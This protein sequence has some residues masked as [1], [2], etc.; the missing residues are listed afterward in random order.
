[1]A[2]HDEDWFGSF[3]GFDNLGIVRKGFLYKKASNKSHQS[4]HQEKTKPLN[5]PIQQ[6]SHKIHE[7]PTNNP[8]T[9][10]PI[11]PS[12]KKRQK[13]IC[14]K[15]GISTLVSSFRAFQKI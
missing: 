11:F 3:D 4:T 5:N 12:L 14:R 13:G 10:P 15:A 1:V 8:P 9:N 2:D 7:N 6:I